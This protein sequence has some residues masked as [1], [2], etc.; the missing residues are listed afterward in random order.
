MLSI[1]FLE[2]VWT[3]QGAPGALTGIGWFPSLYSTVGIKQSKIASGRSEAKST[4]ILK[5]RKMGKSEE[6]PKE[7]NPGGEKNIGAQRRAIC[8]KGWKPPKQ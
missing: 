8:L 3:S 7:E 5:S 2:P 4:G 1:I 6:R